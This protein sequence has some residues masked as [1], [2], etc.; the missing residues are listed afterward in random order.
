MEYLK[1][2]ISE[3]AAHHMV[4]SLQ[5]RARLPPTQHVHLHV[6]D[7]GWGIYIEVQLLKLEGWGWG[8]GIN[9]RYKG[10]LILATPMWII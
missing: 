3:Q 2:S 9:L 1:D 5:A 6:A 10:W 7:H 8:C 4:G